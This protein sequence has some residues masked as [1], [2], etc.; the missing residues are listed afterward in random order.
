ML[1]SLTYNSQMILLILAEGNENDISVLSSL[2]R[3]FGIASCLKVSWTKS[4]LL[5]FL[6]P[7]QNVHIWQT[8]WVVTLKVGGLSIWVYR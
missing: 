2:I 8:F 3:C 5:G 6:Y 4:H 1:M 7:I